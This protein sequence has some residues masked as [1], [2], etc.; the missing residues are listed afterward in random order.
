MNFLQTLSPTIFQRTFRNVGIKC[1]AIKNPCFMKECIFKNVCILSL[2]NFITS[3]FLLRTFIFIS[4]TFYNDNGTADENNIG[5][6]NFDA[7]LFFI[8]YSLNLLY[9][10]FGICFLSFLYTLYLLQWQL[11]FL[12]L[13]GNSGNFSFIFCYQNNWKSHN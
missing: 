9:F 2:C 6:P 3:F 4:P 10:F 7:R 12:A 11:L 5:A 1:I 8:T 13:I